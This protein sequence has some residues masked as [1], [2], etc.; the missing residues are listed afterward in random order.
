MK[1][2]TSVQNITRVALGALLVSTS[3]F[4]SCPQAGL[5]PTVD[6]EAPKVEIISPFT[7]SVVSRIIT[8]SGTASDDKKLNSLSLNLE[9]T[10]YKRTKKIENIAVLEDGIWTYDFDT[11]SLLDDSYSI[12]AE[13]IDAENK[14]SYSTVIYEIDNTAPVLVLDRPNS[15]TESQSEDIDSFGVKISVKGTVTDDHEVRTLS[16]KVYDSPDD[17]DPI[18]EKKFTNFGKDFDL[19]PGDDFYDTAY[20]AESGVKTLYYTISAEDEAGNESEV[21]YL[22]EN[23]ANAGDKDY[24]GITITSDELSGKNIYSANNKTFYAGTDGK[25]DLAKLAKSEKLLEAAMEYEISGVADPHKSIGKFTVEKSST[26]SFSL[27]GISKTEL[28]NGLSTDSLADKVQDVISKTTALSFLISP[29]KNGDLLAANAEDVKARMKVYAVRVTEITA[30]GKLLNGD[31]DVTSQ[32]SGRWTLLPISG[33]V[34]KSGT[35]Y[36]FNVSA[37]NL[38]YY[39]YAIRLVG[40]DTKGHPFENEGDPYLITIESSNA[41]PDIVFDDENTIYIKED[42]SILISGKAYSHVVPTDDD[43]GKTYLIVKPVIAGIELNISPVGRTDNRI[44]CKE[45]LNGFEAAFDFEIKND[46][47]KR[48]LDPKLTESGKSVLETTVGVRAIDDGQKENTEEIQLRYDKELPTVKINSL[49]P[50]LKIDGKDNVNGDLALNAEWNDRNLDKTIVSVVSRGVETTIKEYGSK[51]NSSDEVIDTTKYPDGEDLE[52]KVT[53]YDLAGNITS[54]SRTVHVYQDSDIPS[55][56]F[57]NIYDY[58][59]YADYPADSLKNVFYATTDTLRGSLSDDDGISTLEVRAAKYVEGGT[60]EQAVWDQMAPDSENDGYIEIVKDDNQ[61]KE[62]RFEFKL[63]DKDGNYLSNGEYYLQFRVKDCQGTPSVRETTAVWIAVDEDKPFITLTAS[64]GSFMAGGKPNSISGSVEDSSGEVTLSAEYSFTGEHTFGDFE[65]EPKLLEEY[66]DNFEDG[67]GKWTD[68]FKAPSDSNVYEINYKAKD[69]Y[70]REESKKVT[71]KIDMTPPVIT[72]TDWGAEL[73]K[74]DSSA[75]KQIKLKAEDK[76]ADDNDSNVSGVKA[77]YYR[78]TSEG[79]EPTDWIECGKAGEITVSINFGDESLARFLDKTITL[80]FMGEDSATNKSDADPVGHTF[81]TDTKAP[82]VVFGAMPSDFKTNSNFEITGTAADNDAASEQVVAYVHSRNITSKDG[83]IGSGTKLDNTGTDSDWKFT[84]PAN[85]LA[86]DGL[87]RVTVVA[88]D[89]NGRTNLDEMIDTN[90][91]YEFTADNTAPEIHLSNLSDEDKI[92]SSSFTIN[93][94][95]IEDTSGIE[96]V[97]YTTNKTPVSDDNGTTV[98]NPSANMQINLHDL[99]EQDYEIQIRVKD[100]A[101][102]ITFYPKEGTGDNCFVTIHVD[103]ESPRA[104]FGNSADTTDITLLQ[105]KEN[106]VIKG[107]ADDAKISATPSIRQADSIKLEYNK[108]GTTVDVTSETSW[109]KATGEWTYTLPKDKG[110]GDYVFTLTVTDKAGKTATVSRN[111]KIDTTAPTL[112]ISYPADG[113]SVE[114]G[115]IEIRGSASDYGVGFSGKHIF[116]KL[117]DGEYAGIDYNN[118][119]SWASGELDLGTTEGTHTVSVYAVDALG[120]ATEPETRTFYFDKSQP[121][122]TETKIGTTD[123]VSS[124]ATVEFSGTW[125][126]TNGVNKIQIQYRKDGGNLQLLETFDNLTPPKTAADG[127]ENWSYSKNDFESGTYEFEITIEDIAGKTNTLT[128]RVKIDLAAPKAPA[129]IHAEGNSS[130]SAAGTYYSDKIKFTGTASDDDGQSASGIQKVE[131]SLDGANWSS[132]NMMGT[133]N[134]QVEIPGTSF[135]EEKEYTVYFR[136]IDNSNNVGPVSTIKVLI[137]KNN[138]VATIAADGEERTGAYSTR[139]ISLSG[140][141]SDTNRVVSAGLTVSKDGG[142][143]VAA[144]AGNGDGE[145]SFDSTTGTWTYTKTVPQDEESTYDFVLTVT[146]IAGKTA[147]KTQS[148]KVDTKA[149]ELTTTLTEGAVYTN[150]TTQTFSVRAQDGSSGLAE[151]DAIIAVLYPSSADRTAGSNGRAQSISGN[152][153]T[154]E[155]AQKYGQVVVVTTKDKLGNTKEYA[156]TVDADTVRPEISGINAVPVTGYLKAGD[157]YSFGGTATDNLGV[158]KIE[159]TATLGGVAVNNGTFPY[160]KDFDDG[161]TALSAADLAIPSFAAGTD[162]ANN[163]T[164]RFNITASDKAGNS[165][166]SSVEFVVD[167]SA[168]EIESITDVPVKTTDTVLP[169]LFKGKAKDT[170]TSGISKIEYKIGTDGTWTEGTAGSNW[171]AEVKELAEGSGTI[172]VRATDGAGNV[173]AEVSKDFFYDKAYP[174]VSVTGET[175]RQDN[176][177]FSLAGTAGDTYKLSKVE[178]V[179]TKDGVSYTK[180]IDVSG[181]SADWSAANAFPLSANETTSSSVAAHGADG[182]Y[183]YTVKVTDVA[184]KTT[185]AAQKITVTIDTKAPVAPVVSTP[186][187]S[188][189]GT[190]ALSGAT[191]RFSGT[192]ADND[193][194][195][196]I[197]GVEYVLGTSAQVLD[198]SSTGTQAELDSAGRNWNFTKDLATGNGAAGTLSEGTYYLYVRATDKAGNVGEWSAARVFDVDQSAPSVAID[199]EFTGGVNYFGPKTNSGT[200]T[201]TGTVGD[202]RGLAV[203]DA[204]VLKA[205]TETVSTLGAA[206]VS[207]GTW[208]VTVPSAK[209]NANSNTTIYVTA[210][211]A[212]GKTTAGTCIVYYDNVA[213]S[214]STNLTDNA[215]I[216]D[217]LEKTYT[218]NRN[219]NGSG[220]ASSDDLVMTYNGKNTTIPAGA[221]SVNIKFI[222]GNGQTV[223][224]TAKDAVGNTEE[225]T[226]TVSADVTSPVLGSVTSAPANGYLKK[227]ETFNFGGTASD[228]LGVAKVTVT[229]TKDGNAVAKEVYSHEKTFDAGK[230]SLSSADLAI[231]SFGAGEDAIKNGT[232]RFV[233]TVYDEVG[234]SASSSVEFTV[235]V[236]SPEVTGITAYPKKNVDS[237]TPYT[238][239]GTAEDVG[240]GISTIEYSL[241]SATGP[242]TTAD[243]SGKNWYSDVTLAKEGAGTIYV[244]ATDGAGNTGAVKSQDFYFDKA[245]P[246]ITVNGGTAR[247]ASAQFT[248]EGTATDTNALTKVT[249]TQTKAGTEGSLVKELTVSGKTDSWSAAD[250]FPLSADDTAYTAEEIRRNEADGTYTYTIT[251][252]DDAGKTASAPAVI[253]TIDTK[254]PDVPVISTPKADE[255]GTNALTGTNYKFTGTVSDN[256]GGVGVKKVEYALLNSAIAPGGAPSDSTVAVATLDSAGTKWSFDKGLVDGTSGDADNLGE[257]TYWLYVRATDKADNTSSWS[258]GLKFDIDRSNPSIT[259]D[260]SLTQGTNYFGGTKGNSITLSGTV[261]DTRGLDSDKAVELS[262]GGTE[263]AAVTKADAATGTW[264]AVVH[265]SDVVA[266][267]LNTV[268]VTAKDEVG[269]TVSTTCDVFF[270]NT[271]PTFS[272]TLVNGSSITDSATQTYTVS[273]ADNGVGLADT[274]ALKYTYNSSTVNVAPSETSVTIN[275]SQGNDQTVVFTV[276]DKLGNTADHSYTVN[277]DTESPVLSGLSAVPES[278]YLAKNGTYSFVNGT[279]VAKDNI[280]IASVTVTSVHGSDTSTYYSKTFDT[281]LKNGD[282]SVASSLG[283]PTFEAGTD[284]VKNGTW[285]FT[286]TIADKAGRTT[287]ESVEFAVDVSSPEVTGITAYPKQNVDSI[288]PYTFRGTAEDV[289]SGISTI[290]YSLTSATGS[291]TTADGS[292]K[293]WYSDVELTKEG[294]GTIYV[295]ATDGAGN[296]GEVKSQEYYFD[297][298]SPSITVNG[299]TVRQEQGLFT[300]AGSASDTNALTK[301]TITQTKAGTEGSLT[302]ELTVSGTSADWSA[303]DAFPLSADDTAYT[304]EEISR[305]EADGTYTYTIK[306]TDA[307]EKVTTAPAV[308]VTIDTTAPDVPEISAPKETARAD[309]AVNGTSYK[310]SGTVSDNEGGVGIAKVEYVLGTT[311][312]TLTEAS[313]GTAA[314]LFNNATNWNF[315]KDLATGAGEGEALSEGTYYLYVRATD[316]AGNRSGWSEARV[317]DVDQS[318]PAFA[319]DAEFTA[320]TN[321]FGGFDSEDNAITSITLSGTVS[322]SYKLDDT[323]AVTL[324]AGGN[325]LVTIPASS[326]NAGKWTATINSTDIEANKLTALSITALD[327]VGKTSSVSTSVY[328]D[329]KAPTLTTS[330]KDGESLTTSTTKEYTIDVSDLGSGLKESGYLSYTYNDVTTPISGSSVTITFNE[331]NDQV[332]LF[333][334]EDNL[335]NKT[336]YRFTANVDTKAPSITEITA[337]PAY[338][339]AGD[340]YSFGGKT[341]DEIGVE[342]VKVTA[343]HG[344]ETAD[345]D[346]ITFNPVKQNADLTIKDFAAGT[347]S[348]NNGTWR[349]NITASDKAGNST[350]TTVE[351][352]VDVS[353]PVISEITSVPE[354]SK[355]TVLPFD[356]RGTANDVGDSGLAKIEYSLT[357]AE[358]SWKEAT[359]GKNWIALV[360][361]EELTKEGAGTIYV[362]ATDAAGNTGAVESKAFYFD[363]SKPTVSVTG[364]STRQASALFTL[365]GTAAD[366]NGLTKVTIT[367]SKTGTEGSLTK[368]LTVSGT[369]AGWKA[370]NAFPLSANEIAYT[371]EAVKANS[372][373]GEYTYTIVATD[374]AGKTSAVST[375]TVTIDTTAPNV[376]VIS[377]PAATA[378]ADKAVNGTSYKFSGTVSDNEGGVG[379]AKVEYVLGTTV[380]TLTAA[381]EG[382]AAELYNNGTNWNFTKDLATGSAAEG[383]DALSEGTYYLYVRATDAAGN[384]S[385]WSEARVFDVDQSAPAFAL[386]AEFTAGTNYFGGFDSEDNAIT[387]ITLSGT[388]SDSYKLDDTAAVT[389]KAGGN[390]LVTIPASS[391]NAGK[392]TATINSTDIEANKLTALSITALDGVGKTS[393]VSTSVYYDNKAPT[394]TTSFKDGESLTT[395]TTK[396]YTIDVSDLGSGLKESGYLSYTYYGETT[397]ISGSS[398]TITFHEGNDQVV[399]FNVEDK[400]GNKASYRFTANVD[401]KAP[402]ITEITAAPSYLKAEGTYSFGGKTGDEIGVEKV[403]VTATHGNETTDYETITYNP[404]VK[405]EDLAIKDFE[406]GTDSAN[407]GTWRFNI[408]ASDKAG[409]S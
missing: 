199:S 172:H 285:R 297:K 19:N 281:V 13:A 270:D 97:K 149:P 408:T 6:T 30:D 38:G 267:A 162:S 231:P 61:S 271:A 342:K 397:P 96:E 169:F 269:K 233:I 316:A 54:V 301:V 318:A 183:E 383:S 174:S 222:E 304:A 368:E 245:S 346:A 299:G 151:T 190:K 79:V 375:V 407:N 73:I 396:E 170:G 142:T 370:E 103:Q 386:D 111:V 218:I 75:Y 385:G 23:L 374:E 371:A 45:R 124:G 293:N 85:T 202:T 358:D 336:S 395:S 206:D 65:S 10:T 404:V 286:I 56:T 230:T 380:Q 291:W 134:W 401:T 69:K 60:S 66:F 122:I 335:G 234:K 16:F 107:F 153:L 226:Y 354:Q 205:G 254:A 200:I 332:V 207:E 192:V 229:A 106:L 378:R 27:Q 146:D 18:A 255:T 402:S 31:T 266:N 86:P 198:S 155:F 216:D 314:E 12:T 181:T 80:E 256:Q 353:A 182:T 348:A 184:T 166:S 305:N 125:T 288:T 71:F 264:S 62:Y 186:S 8:I 343:T 276:T 89:K 214:F 178:V 143:P 46:T 262:I 338:L 55:V 185:T 99:K 312:Q 3:L 265:S 177:L 379:I 321:Y 72:V 394:L 129:N 187:A 272:T 33:E 390:A 308:T 351:F 104:T 35:S 337:A 339:K 303:A 392:W 194:G 37:E 76:A 357:G 109:D 341:G 41:K 5:G 173:S 135:S 323:A 376:P 398:V 77:V 250:A 158:K 44:E 43:G 349:F 91:Y 63:K 236:S 9:G 171:L 319:L 74:T 381:S 365:E 220:L 251:V 311:V 340:T 92:S 317:F 42:G 112:S 361:E 263:I 163:G 246:S 188:E 219:D 334:V 355:D 95:I 101:G 58:R 49:L 295:R 369:S 114:N 212:V 15:T 242:W 328:Y 78:V 140:E 260:S 363:R 289:G 90:D 310:F 275:F 352:V 224:F 191:Y 168:P 145:F 24:G 102:N 391:V 113:F 221:T 2:K 57:E 249:I 300:L 294:A 105:S 350:S 240:S 100:K 118:S 197:A 243:G 315:T 21:F 284:S 400:L 176:K 52:I 237:I 296:I 377:S 40:K 366:T 123:T 82:S 232:W 98:S 278:G 167:V 84:V 261:S 225:Y 282:E 20:G 11:K 257:G 133:S 223:K 147:T 406:A 356:F 120:N 47:I 217:S 139:T 360:T 389:L 150:K 128:R 203:T 156:Y 241:T 210:K 70:G 204:I 209:V 201:I 141:A 320:G 345:Y 373:D 160:T 306:V 193:G 26:P 405:S 227:G 287:S 34:K 154:V 51:F 29:N 290:E 108:E 252:T 274:G 136:A 64:E 347:D 130:T 22:R 87:W 409:N 180:T 403:K 119:A 359:T 399:L 235:D 258:T 126:E 367:Q 382:T 302:K 387:S 333:N 175:I 248:L 25:D 117:D 326:V 132:D 298:A 39:T 88:T 144:T 127:T 189:T 325:A 292:G 179:Q 279:T 164:W 4:F 228:N 211:D 159:V 244:R 137:D 372:A 36:T 362:R 59:T 195:V 322:D 116:Y 208:S 121:V 32:E 196:G 48:Y 28:G 131:Y 157:T 50:T 273:R 307:A 115:E 7:K 68:S 138:P 81:Y 213:P 14:K 110:D 327:G 247:Q 53:T 277:V 152:S 148:L 253:V 259:I 329:N 364:E 393:S 83:I 94:S 238:F 268:K 283:I 239:R 17:V 384:K 309:K 161:K 388:V 93:G 330:F 331:G 344:N 165:T 280:G 1:N 67:A 215:K 324:K 313:E